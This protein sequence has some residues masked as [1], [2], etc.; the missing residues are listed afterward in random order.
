MKISFTKQCMLLSALII[1][2]HII[3]M[4]PQENIKSRELAT[5]YSNLP[6]ELQITIFKHLHNKAHAQL[7]N[8]NFSQ[9]ISIKSLDIFQKNYCNFSPKHM[10]R[11]L[12]C[13]AYN[14]NHEGVENILKNSNILDLVENQYP[15]FYTEEYNLKKAISLNLR[16]MARYNN[17]IKMHQILDIYNVYPLT[18][19]SI[20]P[21]QIDFF[22]NCL[23]GKND[24]NIVEQNYDETDLSNMVQS[25]NLAIDCN[26]GKYITMVFN[27]IDGIRMWLFGT[28]MLQRAIK[29]NHLKAVEALLASKYRNVFDVNANI[30]TSDDD[31]ISRYGCTTLLDTLLLEPEKN[32][33]VI[34]L[35][36]KYGAKTAND[37]D[38]ELDEEILAGAK[39]D[40]PE[41]CI[42]S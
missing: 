35:L 3:C 19:Q 41:K 16:E 5:H 33:A 42:I 17:D 8:K 32:A 40:D 34:S 11:I 22:M 37:L 18:S 1:T 36:K 7:I 21:K 24:Q 25:L 20:A 15:H 31:L 6:S 2:Q 23:T 4:E 26:N 38:D 10:T 29:Q 30:K 28:T 13:A 12:L 27:C 39:K 14:K 9:S